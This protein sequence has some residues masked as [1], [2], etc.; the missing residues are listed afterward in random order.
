[1]V[2][3]DVETSYTYILVFY[4]M[5]KQFIGKFSQFSTKSRREFARVVIP[6]SVFYFFL[7][8]GTVFPLLSKRDEFHFCKS[9]MKFHRFTRTLKLVTHVLS[10]SYKMY[11]AFHAENNPFYS[12]VHKI[13]LN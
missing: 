1:M 4:I 5:Y 10:P 11:T 9:N 3:C 13:R 7:Y 6:S 2:T 12:V 8:I